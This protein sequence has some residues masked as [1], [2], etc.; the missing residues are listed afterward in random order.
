MKISLGENIKITSFLLSLE[1][2]FLYD[3]R[4]IW[5]TNLAMIRMHNLEVDLGL[6]TYTLGINQFSDMVDRHC[7]F[8]S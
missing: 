6:Q 4:S 7:F 1:V 3:S 2:V 8:L 5:E